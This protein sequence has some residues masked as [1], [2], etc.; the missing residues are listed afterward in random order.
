MIEPKDRVERC[1]RNTAHVA[2]SLQVGLARVP[3]I[4]RASHPILGV[5]RLVSHIFFFLFVLQWKGLHRTHMDIIMNIF[6]G[7]DISRLLGCGRFV[8]LVAPFC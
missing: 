4:V 3:K 5:L 6:K 8:F 7:K 2:S 1:H